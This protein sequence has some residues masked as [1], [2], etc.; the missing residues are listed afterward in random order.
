MT[1][2]NQGVPANLDYVYQISDM[3][4][5]DDHNE[6]GVEE[7]LGVNVRASWAGAQSQFHN[8]VESKFVAL[9][10][11][12][13]GSGTVLSD[14]ENRIT[15][16]ESGN[17]I[18]EFFDNDI[19]TKPQ[20]NQDPDPPA[21]YYR[22][23][24]IGI[25]GGG[26]GRSPTTRGFGSSSGTDTYGGGQ[27]GYGSQSHLNA[28]V[29][30]TVTVVIGTPGLASSTNGTNGGSGTSTSFTDSGGSLYS[31]GGGTG[32]T[33]TAT[34]ARGSGTTY[35]DWS[36]S[37]GTG[38]KVTGASS[39]E[40]PTPGNAGYLANGGSPGTNEGTNGGNGDSC[41]PGRIGPGGGGGGG[42]NTGRGGNGG[43]PGGGGGG[44]GT[45]GGLTSAGDGGHGGAGRGV[46]ISYVT[47]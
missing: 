25:G 20:I 36:A 7:I 31:A 26:A 22:H 23:E 28:D 1:T 29:D 16:L 21:N 12:L 45:N 14:H 11:E 5:A 34:G 42:H 30:A 27:G 37:G 3:S 39:D 15:V 9:E 4:A 18:A 43:F 47:A 8:N 13:I 17:V 38:F 40:Q 10:D 41:P 19:W 2:P 6:S 44:G 35:T 32:G 24:F 46:I 33:N